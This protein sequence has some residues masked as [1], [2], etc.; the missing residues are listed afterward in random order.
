MPR[1]STNVQ[2]SNVLSILCSDI[3]LAVIQEHLPCELQEFHRKYLWLPLCKKIDKGSVT[4]HYQRDSR[5]TSWLESGFDDTGWSGCTSSVCV[6]T[7][8]LVYFSMA[9]ELPAWAIKAI[10]K[11]QRDFHGEKRMPKALTS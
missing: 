4:A 6:L 7:L 3:D 8:V 9:I 1:A 5:S 11:I 10:E 2:K